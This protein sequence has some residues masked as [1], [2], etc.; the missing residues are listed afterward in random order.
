MS[1][2]FGVSPE[3][4]TS[5]MRRVAK[6]INF[7]IAYGMSPYGLSKELKIDSASAE[8]YIKRYFTRYPKV[9][10]YIE[11]TIEFAK[12][13]G[14]VQT[15]SGRK[16]FIPEIFSPTRSVRE[17]GYRMAVN[18]PIQGSAADLMK[19]AMVALYQALQE[20][21]LNSNLLL[22]VHDELLLEVPE[23]ELEKVISLAQ[24]IMLNPFTYLGLDLSLT[25]P[26]KVN[27]S[28]G[29]SWADCKS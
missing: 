27:A 3:K 17:L 22:Q 18:T 2:C 12:E 9:K 16:R 7:G 20:E 1:K 21:G 4:V 13:Q 23:E 19:A 5:E 28:Y 11:K 8:A 25:V 26:L 15:I 6:I 24:E 29:K 10:E 14:Y